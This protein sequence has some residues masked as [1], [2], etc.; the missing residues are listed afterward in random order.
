M[1]KKTGGAKRGHFFLY[2]PLLLAAARQLPLSDESPALLDVWRNAVDTNTHDP[3][4]LKQGSANL[5]C[6]PF[7]APGIILQITRF[8]PHI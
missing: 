1:G 8:P 3:L 6:S 4:P 2:P 5:V 7:A